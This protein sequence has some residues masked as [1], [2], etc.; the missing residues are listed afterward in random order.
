MIRLTSM[1]AEV[2]EIVKWTADNQVYY[3]STLPANPGAR[4]LFKLQIGAP[5]EVCSTCTIHQQMVPH[6]QR[7]GRCEY[8][9][10][11]MSEGGSFYMMSCKGPNIPYSTLV[12]TRSNNILYNWHQN[13]DIEQ[14]VANIDLPIVEFLQIGVYG[15]DQKAQIKLHI[16]AELKRN[17]WRKKFP[18][19]VEVY[20]GPG[21]QKVTRR[22]EMYD[23][24]PYLSSAFGIVCAYIDG[25]GSG[26]QG[27]R[28]RHAVYRNFGSVEVL[29][30]I[31]VTKH[32]Q[33]NLRFIDASRTGIWGWSYGGFLTLS[34]L[35]QD[36]EGIFKCGASV[37]PVVKWEL[38]DTIYTERYMSTPMDNPRGY[39]MSTPLW[40]LDNLR[41]KMFYLIHGT[42]DDNVHYQQS[43]LLSAALA[44][45]DI[46][47]RQQAYPDQASYV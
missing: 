13:N 29:D 35:T 3:V 26:F 32:L 5:F 27:L 12:H 18:M 24:C 46:L 16:P 4:H 11:S 45:K 14:S 6:L 23:F 42:H 7:R 30:T 9:D 43:M 40:R 2:T 41:S 37:A 44:E 28:W 19:L 34:V 31:T 8:V 1:Y 21:S 47:F 25:R 20:G 10:I 36:T 39:N 22:W 17:K 38:Y 33:D 15:S